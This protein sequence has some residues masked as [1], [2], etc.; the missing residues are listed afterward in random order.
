MKK[1]H[2]MWA[3]MCALGASLALYT[4]C[5]FADELLQVENPDEIMIQALDDISLLEVQVNGVIG[6]FKSA[7]DSPIIEYGSY[8]TDE[9]L[10]GV[11][12]EGTA[13]MNQRMLHWDEGQTNNI[14]EQSHR[15]IRQGHNLAEQIR[16][17]V[18]ISDS[19]ELEPGELDEDLATVLVFTGY[20]LVAQA[21][22]MCQTVISPD[23][24]EPSDAVL[25][26]AENYAAAEGYL[27]EALSLATG[28]GFTD[29]ADLARTGLARA[30][31][32]QGEWSE[33]ATYANAV[34]AG[35]EWW[36]EYLDQDNG[37]NPLNNSSYGGNFFLGIHPW[38]TG[39]HP[40]FDRTGYTFLDEDVIDAQTDPR[41]QHWP[42]ERKGHNGLTPMYKLFQGLRYSDYTGMTI[43]PQSAACPGCTVDSDGDGSGWDVLDESQN[44]LPLLAWYGTDILLADYVEAQ[45]HYWESQSMQNLDEA[46]VLAFVNARRAVGNQAA[47]AFTSQALRTELRNQRAKDLFMGGFRTGDLRRWER[48]DAGNG[49]FAAGSYFPTG[50]HPNA[51]WG[52]YSNW[53]CFPIPRSEYEG[54]QNLQAPAD[55]SVP[56]GL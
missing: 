12:W 53:T 41:I 40:S 34:S 31:M 37:R 13:R 5:D 16:A 30:H 42:S 24:D 15:A 51:Q 17:W 36:L 35:F 33:A 39:T 6:M 27:T 14:W 56:P 20:A 47:V 49:P 9:I 8:H 48:F 28:G 26:N 43:A 50:T 4:G 11:N 1:K 46:G 23:P 10:V 44:D 3:G 38:F 21:D 54:N 2:T 45:H 29:L 19:L 25:S 7:Y 32:G 55:P 22:H 52:N 18:A